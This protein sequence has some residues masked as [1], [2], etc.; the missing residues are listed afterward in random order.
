MLQ[1]LQKKLRNLV[2]VLWACRGIV[3]LGF[4]TS[5]GGNVLSA[6]KQPIPIGIS[7][8]APVIL[9]SAFEVMSRIP[10]PE[11]GAGWLRWIATGI[12]L[13]AMVSIVIIM[14]VTSY[15]H[16]SHAFLMYGKDH[17]QAQWLPWA[18]DA[19][20]IVGSLSVIEVQIF[21][22]KYEMQIAGLRDAKAAKEKVLETPTDKQPNGRERIAIAVKEMP[23]GTPKEVA[24]RAQVK[25]NYAATV[26][27]ELRRAAAKNGNGHQ[28]EPVAVN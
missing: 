10:F 20:M 9:L 15:R 8:I 14:M 4:A 23:W 1:Q 26:M 21:I 19:F 11:K 24:A 2:H 6:E 17:L 7:L 18:I 27:S 16:Q 3:A 5:A 25:E 22:R 28:A 13:L 12:R